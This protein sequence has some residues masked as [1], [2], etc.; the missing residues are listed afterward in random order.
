MTLKELRISKNL[1]QLEASLICSIP[2]RSYKRLENDTR[3][4]SS[5]KYLHACELIEQYKAKDDTSYLHK[6]IT[7]VGLGYVGL[8]NAI[9]LAKHN[10]V[11]IIDIDSNKIN[12]IRNKKSPIKNKD[13]WLK[14][15]SLIYD[16]KIKQVELTIEW[17]KGHANFE[18]NELADHLAK[19]AALKAT[20]IDQ[21]YEKIN[22]K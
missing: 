17:I 8:A 15:H 19:E 10:K 4:V 12:L 22:K 20:E 11:Y 6:T 13:L 5:Y 21:E 1:T 7:V 18:Y 2:L 16:F 14:I 9:A 3:Y